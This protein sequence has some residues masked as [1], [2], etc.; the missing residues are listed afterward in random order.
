MEGRRGR[1]GGGERK[2]GMRRGERRDVRVLPSKTESQTRMVMWSSNCKHIV[3][4]GKS[5]N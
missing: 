1:R 2:K 3:T 4:Q 5:N